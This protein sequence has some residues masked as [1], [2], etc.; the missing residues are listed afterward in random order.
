ML[1]EQS[2]VKYLMRQS[3]ICKENYVCIDTKTKVIKKVKI[4]CE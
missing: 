2:F 1:F 4:K 3:N